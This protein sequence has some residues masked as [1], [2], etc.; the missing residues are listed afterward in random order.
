MTSISPNTGQAQQWNGEDGADWVRNA[1]Q[2]D[3]MADGFT[4]HLFAAAAIARG[5]EVL[6]IGCGAGQTT[7]LA[8][9]RAVRGHA[10]GVDVSAPMLGLARRRAAEENV[11]NATFV[12]GDAQVHR[13]PTGRFTVAISRAGVMFFAD[14]VAAFANIRGA[15]QPG[16][17]LVFVCHRETNDNP[18]LDALLG[19]G[20]TMNLATQAP[21]VLTFTD[22]EQVRDILTAAGFR[23]ESAT[24]F[25]V[26]STIHGTASD[27]ADYLTLSVVLPR[28]T[29]GARRL[30]RRPRGC[31]VRR[32]VDHNL[33]GRPQP[34]RPGHRHRPPPCRRRAAS[35]WALPGSDSAV[36]LPVP[37]TP[38]II[39]PQRAEIW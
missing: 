21:G 32:P 25:A 1:E 24:P 36:V 15:L 26:V 35:S 5:D 3:T 13:F 31:A 16:G 4:E 17:R 22:R 39:R 30:W 10:T 19:A 38:L 9:R 12:L 7:R 6:D 14:P 29:A 28:S 34:R 37:D 11:P 23:S 27:A 18:V 33:V 8:A 2:Y 20:I